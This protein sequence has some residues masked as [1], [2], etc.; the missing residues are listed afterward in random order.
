MPGQNDRPDV[1]ALAQYRNFKY[2][3]PD[4]LRISP[5]ALFGESGWLI[6]GIIVNYD[7]MAY[8]ERVAALFQ[9]CLLDRDSPIV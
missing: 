1:F 8:W 2:H 3:L 7:A 6:D 5:P 9:A 4:Y